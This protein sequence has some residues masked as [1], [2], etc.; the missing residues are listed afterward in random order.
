VRL[1]LA[2]CVLSSAPLGANVRAASAPVEEKPNVLLIVLDDLG[3]EKLAFY[4]QSATH[5]PTPNLATLRQQGILFTQAYASPVCSPSRAM[6]Q[7]GRYAFR[8]GVGTNVSAFTLSSEEVTLA[9]MLKAGF[10]GSPIGYR[11]GAFG[12]WHLTTSDREHPCANGYDEFVGPLAN[13]ANHFSW[14]EIT[15]TATGSA[16]ARW[17]GDEKHGPF[18]T[19][20]WDAS[21]VRA[22]A[23]EWIGRQS[24]PFFAYVAFNPPHA[25]LQV[26][27]LELLS[28]AT[29][30]R[31]AQ[32]GYAAGDIVLASDPDDALVNDWMI[33]AVDAE[34]GRLLA[35]IAE[36]TRKRTLVLVVGDN[37]THAA[38]ARP[39]LERDHAKGTVYQGG[40]RVPMLASGYGVRGAPATCS[41]LVSLVDVWP[42]LAALT[43][44]QVGAIDPG[45]DCGDGVLDGVSFQVLLANPSAAGLRA[46]AFAQLFAP[47]G[48]YEPDPVLPPTKSAHERAL[49]D[50]RFKYLRRLPTPSG[51]YREEAYDLAADPY[52][53]NDLWPVL[54]S[55]PPAQRDALLLLQAQTIALSGN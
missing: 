23:L 39:P 55:L 43:G 53:L 48:C 35:G 5:P 11:C 38:V 6:L 20:T 19:T 3:T 7:T 14:R 13:N 41:G 50:G 8:T 32:E 26:P 54:G 15:D 46:R 25:P 52:E 16:T 40:V 34:V 37:G 10:A 21:V 29:Q 24:G 44:A 1:T 47:I 51:P 30:A 27:P 9:E 12:K 33:E 28:P 31:V 49:T 45:G 2:L 36:E 17:V 4:G 22:A 42:T 18:D